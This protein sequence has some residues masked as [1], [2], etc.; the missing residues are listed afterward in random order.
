MPSWQ[1][2]HTVFAPARAVFFPEL[3]Y[4]ESSYGIGS[5]E[6]GDDAAIAYDLQQVVRQRL[7]VDRT[8][9]EPPDRSLQGVDYRD[10]M[11]FGVEPLAT[12]ARAE[13]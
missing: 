3:R 7:A 5:R 9:H 10:P 2:R 8:A 13:A 12:I 1:L 11:K 4:A 6:I